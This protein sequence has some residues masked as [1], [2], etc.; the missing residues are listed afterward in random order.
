MRW[1]WCGAQSWWQGSTDVFQVPQSKV[2]L[3]QMPE[4]VLEGP[5]EGVRASKG[6]CLGIRLQRSGDENSV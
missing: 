3:R 2:L 5:Q 6:F 1:L 4:E